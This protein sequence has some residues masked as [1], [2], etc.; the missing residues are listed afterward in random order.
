MKTPS[1]YGLLPFQTWLKLLFSEHN[2]INPDRE[3]SIRI[4]DIIIRH[5]GTAFT[6]YMD[7]PGNPLQLIRN[8]QEAI[9]K[10]MMVRA[11]IFHLLHLLTLDIGE[12]RHR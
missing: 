9:P 6:A 2:L 10:I 8:T 4:R 12:K 3:E 7:P 11:F 1:K 5:S